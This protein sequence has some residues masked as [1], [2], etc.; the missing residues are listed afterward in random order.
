MFVGRKRELEKL[1]ELY[2][3]GKF[4][5]AVIYGRRRVGKTTLINEF[6]KGKKAIYYTGLE[7][8][9]RE[10]LENLSRSV[11]TARLGGE[12]YAVFPGYQA[13]LDTLHEMSAAERVVM[14]ID[15]YPYL[16]GAYGG[17]SSLLQVQIDNK[18]KNGKLMLILCGSSMSF[19]EN[20]VLG[21]KSPLFGRRTAQFKIQPFD[22]FEAKSY[23]KNFD[24]HEAAM[25]Y[26]LTGGIPQYLELMDDNLGVAENIK[27]SFFD[28][29]AFL[30]EE[31]SN[32]L[33]QEVREPAHYNAI[34]RSIATG[35]TRNSEIAARADMETGACANYLKNLISLGIVSKETPITETSSRK[36]IYAISDS[37]FRFWYRFVPDNAALIHSGMSDRLWKKVE[38][39]MPDFMGR[40][41]EEICKQWLWRENAADRLPVSFVK[42]GRWWG[43]DSIRRQQ[44]EIDI[45]ALSEEDS[46]LFAECKW[47]KEKADAGV[48]E[49]LVHRAEL[50]RFREKHLYIFS[51][52]GFTD[53]CADKA[54]KLNVVLLSFD[55]MLRGG[56]RTKTPRAPGYVSIPNQAR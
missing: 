25:I 3:S 11:M 9:S 49:T 1:N 34:I 4:E 31:P 8:S 51:R 29:N 24:P 32:L 28:P 43:N 45:L 10:N 35:S 37:M 47:T 30:F 26:G 13:A 27:R 5:C 23:H 53:R 15:E 42:L 55:E 48:L 50:F 16:A 46:A 52:S 56:T 17:I 14:V 2:G 39:Q 36:T 22:F 18:F 44:A 7:T 54:K 41:F 33:K 40:V 6:V 38:P 21:Y 20:Q 19:M 12:T